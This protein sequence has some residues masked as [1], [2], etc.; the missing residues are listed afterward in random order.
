MKSWPALAVLS[1][2]A[3]TCVTGAARADEAAKTKARQHFKQGVELFDQRRFGDALAQ[4]EQSYGLFPVYSTLYNV[5]QVHV[6]LG[7]PVQAVEA[8]EK[9][10]VQGGASVPAEQRNRVESELKL[11]R[12]RVGELKLSVLPDAAVVRVDG[13]PVGKAPLNGLVKVAAGHHRIEAM[14]DGYRSEQNE[15]DVPGKG[16][17]ELA[18]KLVALAPVAQPAAP[19]PA[20]EAAPARP[21]AVP[22]ILP[23]APAPVATP[24][25]PPPNSAAAPPEQHAGSS[26]GGTVQRVFG[27]LFAGAGLVG[28]GVGIALAVDG[29]SKHDDALVQWANGDKAT[30]QQTESASSKEKSQGYVVIGASGAVMLT[31]AI[32]LITAP[33][34]HS[35]S[36]RVNWSPWVGTSVAGASFGGTW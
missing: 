27:Y 10:L 30:A 7:H 8:F 29:Q 19:T 6:A 15:I 24:K 31:G 33:S 4:F 13:D 23:V 17:V 26:S 2:L 12:E 20:V 11:Q 36:A 3:A 35:A 16:H 14:L 5:G 34:G 9:L 25:Q 1:I 28:S 22:A 21:T 18:F 32:L